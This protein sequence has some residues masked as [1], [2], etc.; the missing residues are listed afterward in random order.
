[1]DV[2]GAIIGGAVGEWMNDRLGRKISILG[3]DIVL[4]FGTIVMAIA[5]APWVFIVGRILVGFGV[6]IA[7]MTFPLYISEASPAAIRRAL[8]CIN[9]LLIIFG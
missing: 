4:F 7:S 3:A 8:V 2:T 6:G 9:G 1:M 5:Q